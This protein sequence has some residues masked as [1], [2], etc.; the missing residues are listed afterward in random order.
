[1]AM[2]SPWL[3][4]AWVLVVAGSGAGLAIGCGTSPAGVHSG[5]DGGDATAEGAVEEPE[6]DAG[7]DIN[8]NPNVYPAVHH[9]V[10]QLDYSG[11]P[12]LQHPRIVTVTFTGNAHR[13]AVRDFLHFIPT[14]GWWQQTAE[15]FCIDAGTYAGQ[16]VGAGT[17]VAPDGGEWRPD[18]STADG[19]DGYLD[20][21]LGYDFPG[22]MVADDDIQ[23]WL[24]NH[25][26]AGD[27][28]KPDDQTIYF[29][30][31]PT[32]TTITLGTGQSLE[33]SC[34]QFGGYH[35]SIAAT[36][37]GSYGAVYAVLPYCP[38]GISDDFDYQQLIL[39]TSHELAEAATD[40]HVN[41]PN[42]IAF[43]LFSNDAWIAQPGYLGGLGGECGDL[44]FLVSE[45]SLYVG[46]GGNPYDESGYNV[47]RI[48][49]N[50]AAAQSMQPCQPWSPTYYGAALRTQPQTIPATDAL[51]YSHVSDGY[52]FV[53]RGQSV[54]VVADV[55]SQA[56]LPHD[57]V[58][59]AGVPKQGATDPSD[60]AAPD[61]L[62]TVS[63][64]QSQVNNGTGVVV[65]FSASSKSSTGPYWLVLRSVL[66]TNDYNDWPVI[67][68][69][70]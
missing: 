1:M 19:G 5:K 7:P 49:S 8:Q 23:T 42:Q 34:Q 29:I 53:K 58:L 21:E 17:A 64:S 6:V 55:F 12:I 27:F 65:T 31:F 2:R 60:L 24:G 50:Q 48:W 3:V 38:S 15:G 16:C 35:G 11:G 51:P 62:I 18:G 63:L 44:C 54:D 36:D 56:A 20:V 22:P 52:V 47:T 4:L 14:T 28:P 39:A 26:A 43:Y 68:F 30:F 33:T 67:V 13:D 32:T 57:L 9:P 46:G 69:V 40:P 66:E 59:Y 45:S 70:Q 37:S 41:L 61:D 10:P 25:I